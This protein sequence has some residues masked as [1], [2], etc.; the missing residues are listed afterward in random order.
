VRQRREIE[1]DRE[2]EF[3]RERE[4]LSERVR[5]AESESGRG[6]NRWVGD[7]GAGDEWRLNR[8]GSTPIVSWVLRWV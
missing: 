5:E 6:E 7:E 8:T 2:S 1:G 3:E 4:M